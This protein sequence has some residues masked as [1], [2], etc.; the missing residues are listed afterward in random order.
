MAINR[1]RRFSDGKSVERPE[2]DELTEKII[3]LCREYGVSL[4]HEDRGGSFEWDAVDERNEKWLREAADNRP[5]TPEEMA[6]RLAREAKK[7]EDRDKQARLHGELMMARV[8]EVIEKGIC[9]KCGSEIQKSPGSEDKYQ[10]SNHGANCG[11][12]AFTLTE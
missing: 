1:Y 11:F 8:R 7:K 10:C 4:A 5:E 2:L 3:D 9:P 12:L 6:L